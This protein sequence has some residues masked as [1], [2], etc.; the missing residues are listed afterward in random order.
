MKVITPNR[1]NCLIAELQHLRSLGLKVVPVKDKK[2]LVPFAD[3]QS[4]PTNIIEKLILD[5][6][7]NGLGLRLGDL[8]V[9]DIDDPDPSWVSKALARFGNTSVR[10]RT[11]SGGIHLYYAGQLERPPNL[12]DEGW[13]VDVKTGENQ[14][15]VCANSWRVDGRSYC[16]EGNA[17]KDGPLPLILDNDAAPA[18]LHRRLR[19]AAKPKSLEATGAIIPV[20][21][22]HDY[23]IGRAK[24]LARNIKSET[25]L[26]DAL[27]SVFELECDTSAPLETEEL[28][29]IARWCWKLQQEGQN[30]IQGESYVTIP[31]WV[32]EP[33]RGNSAAQHLFIVIQQ[34][35]GHQLGKPFCLDH[36]GMRDAGWTDLGRDRFHS[37]LRALLDAGVIVVSAKY[38]RAKKKTRYK[39][40]PSPADSNLT[41][42]RQVSVRCA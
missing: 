8:T 26:L 23:L 34:L 17:V 10:V 21:Q 41:I 15:V 14:Y 36:K 35:H 6:K 13:P 39:L 25:A 38:I 18:P 33:L 31:G 27:R 30:Y 11:P 4:L 9:I 22:R 7:A 2:P 32:M 19:G 40:S 5:G 42:C 28:E 24:L 3:R 37:A 1:Q 29:E 12:K 16:V 20:G